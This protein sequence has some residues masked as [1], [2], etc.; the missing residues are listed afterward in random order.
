MKWDEKRQY[1]RPSSLGFK[2]SLSFKQDQ[3][4]AEARSFLERWWNIDG[5]SE[6]ERQLEARWIEHEQKC[7][8]CCSVLV[9]W[10]LAQ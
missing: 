2:S 9:S 1:F 10:R 8:H 3:L 7:E 5:A 6:E 4:C